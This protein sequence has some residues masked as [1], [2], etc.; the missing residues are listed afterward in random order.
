MLAL[1]HNFFIESGNLIIAN[2]DA[3]KSALDVDG[4]NDDLCKKNAGPTN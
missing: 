1:K 4:D 3:Y 2:D